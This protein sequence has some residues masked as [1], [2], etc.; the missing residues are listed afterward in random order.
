MQASRAS[1]EG[2]GPIPRES[3]AHA[4]TPSPRPAPW[5]EAELLPFADV[6]RL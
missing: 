4:V 5:S 3:D 2:L 6:E 1:K